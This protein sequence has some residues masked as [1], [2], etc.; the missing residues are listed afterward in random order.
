MARLP[1]K[2]KRKPP[3]TSLTLP[4]R[5]R[6]ATVPSALLQID[7]ARKQFGGV[8][9]RSDGAVAVQTKAQAARYIA[10]TSCAEANGDRSFCVAADR[11]CAQA[12]RRRDR[13]I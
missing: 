2:P 3:D 4:A 13:P 6:T 10:D 7:N 5:K 9:A 1:F 8:I 11:Q 12:V